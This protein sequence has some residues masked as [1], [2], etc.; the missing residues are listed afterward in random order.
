[1]WALLM[2]ASVM[3]LQRNRT[4]NECVCV[5]RDKDFKELVYVVLWGLA[6]LKSVGLADGNSG[7]N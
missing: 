1:M 3:I 4:N 2:G 6:I 7:K 5:Q